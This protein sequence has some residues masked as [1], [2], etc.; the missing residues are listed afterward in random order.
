MVKPVLALLPVL[1]LT[2]LFG[3]LV[4]ISP[5]WAYAAVG[6][7]SF[8]VFLG[9]GHIELG[10]EGSGTLE[11]REGM[12]FARTDRGMSRHHRRHPTTKWGIMQKEGIRETWQMVPLCLQ[13]GSNRG[14]LVHWKVKEV[15]TNQGD[16]QGS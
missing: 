1:G 5:T 3:L 6:L 8:Q 11:L 14:L 7:N 13:V 4:H 12:W 10:G 2:W 15:E 16:G 9:I